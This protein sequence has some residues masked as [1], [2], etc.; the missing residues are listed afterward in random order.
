MTQTRFDMPA[1]GGDKTIVT[2]NVGSTI[3]TSVVRV[4]L[5]DA[6]AANKQQVLDALALITQR[7]Q[8]GPWPLAT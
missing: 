8:E 7:I 6:T 3:G 4:M 2:L 1:A 5:D